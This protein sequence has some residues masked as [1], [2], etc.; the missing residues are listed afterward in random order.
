MRCRT[1]RHHLNAYIVGELP[2]EQRRRVGSHLAQCEACR[3]AYQRELL[4]ARQLAADLPAF[5]R[6][7]AAQLAAIW[8]RVNAQRRQALPRRPDLRSASALLTLTLTL[9]CAAFVFRGSAAVA[10]PLPPAP[11]VVR[12]TATPLF[13]ETPDPLGKAAARP[14]A[15]LTAMLAQAPSAAPAPNARKP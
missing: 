13:T 8:A 4:T 12:A 10:A 11:A 15:S 5:G 3:A 1:V 14:T 6:P 9:V 2:P 7:S